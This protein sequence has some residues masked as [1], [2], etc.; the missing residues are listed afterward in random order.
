MSGRLPN[1]FSA[2]TKIKSAEMNAV[3]NYLLNLPQGIMF[4]GYISRTVS[5]NNLT[6]AIKTLAGN[7][8]S[9]ADP[10]NVRINNT[11]YSITS[12]LSFTLNAGTNYFGAGGI[13]FQ[14]QQ[15]DYFVYIGYRASTSTVFLGMARTPNGVV[16]SD[17]NTVNTH[18]NYLAYSGAAPAATDC[19]EVVGRLNATLGPTA[20]FN[21]SLPAASVIVNHPIFHTRT[22]GTNIV[23]TW[24]STPPSTPTTLA[25]YWIIGSTLF[26]RYRQYCT[27]AGTTNTQ[28]SWPL[29]FTPANLTASSSEIPLVGYVSTGATSVDPNTWAITFIY[30]NSTIYQDFASCSAKCAMVAGQYD[31][32]VS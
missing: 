6:V 17:F 11:I 16:Y 15:I 28:V 13:Y 24:N 19:V 30:G 26:F 32:A 21:W 7:D 25:I 5:S 31:I 1:I 9:E 14:A 18:E 3:L 10:V 27:G 8:P 20:S 23:P 22:L 4:N 29:P 2:K 12:A